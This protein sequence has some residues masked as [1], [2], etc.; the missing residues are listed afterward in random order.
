MDQKAKICQ[1]GSDE[2][3]I[4]RPVDQ[5]VFSFI[6]AS[7]FIPVIEVGRYY[8]WEAKEDLCYSN[9]LPQGYHRARN[10]MGIRPLDIVFDDTSPVRAVI[11]QAVFLGSMF[12]YFVS[13][14]GRELRLHRS[15]LDSL[16]GREYS[17]GD[18]IGLRFINEKYYQAE[19]AGVSV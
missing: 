3:I 2:E 17:E 16:D 15:T 8:L 18:R 5:F 9:T 11:S 19:N 6:G 14:G 4:Q 10:L 7:N 1:M 13:L 12:V